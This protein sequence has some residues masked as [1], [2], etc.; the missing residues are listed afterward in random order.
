MTDAQRLSA[1]L[2]DWQLDSVV[3][4]EPF[5]DYTLPLEQMNGLNVRVIETLTVRRPLLTEKDAEGY[6]AALAQVND[7]MEEAIG[8]SQRLAAKGILPPQAGARRCG[9]RPRRSLRRRSIRHGKKRLRC[10]RNSFEPR[11]TMR[12]S[13]A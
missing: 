8:E 4:E 10:C 13:G 1:D 2:M 12:D 9:R 11:P 7:R 6:V 3:R 5:L